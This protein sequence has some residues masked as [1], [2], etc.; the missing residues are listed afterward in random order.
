[1]G[2][3]NMFYLDGPYFFELFS[4]IFMLS[5]LKKFPLYFESNYDPIQSLPVEGGVALWEL[6]LI[7]QAG[8]VYFYRVDPL[9]RS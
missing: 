5:T 1:M 3:N 6:A 7:A 9:S 4:S 2:L 8:L